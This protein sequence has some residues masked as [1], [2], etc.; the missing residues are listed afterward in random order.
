MIR[1]CIRRI[2][3]IA[4][5]TL[6]L[7]GSY[8]NNSA[9]AVQDLEAPADDLVIYNFHCYEP[10]A[11][12]HQGAPWV[13]RLDQSVRIGFEA[14]GTTEAYFEKLFE[15]AIQAA[16]KNRTCLYCGEYGV[17]D[18]ASPEDAVKWF[19]TIHAVFEKHGISRAA[20]SYRRMDFGLSDG[21]MDAVRDELV[22]VL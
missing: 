5:E 10:L 18:R 19:R 1:E 12:T 3:K 15:S 2:R 14:S 20:W 16:E 21:R 7:V 17:I 6:I 8:W 4:P 13:D 11:F 22:K 9:E